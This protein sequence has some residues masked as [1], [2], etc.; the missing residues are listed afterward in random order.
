MIFYFRSICRGGFYEL[1]DSCSSM[2]V[3]SKKRVQS[4][5]MKTIQQQKLLPKA[6]G[7]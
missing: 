1:H 4:R 6:I 7:L 2:H 3:N 5:E